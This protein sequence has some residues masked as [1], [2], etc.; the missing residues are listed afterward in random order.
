[1][2]GN[3]GQNLGKTRV[4]GLSR[5]FPGWCCWGL[6]GQPMAGSL[7][8]EIGSRRFFLAAPSVETSHEPR[9]VRQ[10]RHE[11]AA[12]RTVRPHEPDAGYRAA[13]F[14]PVRRPG[15]KYSTVDLVQNGKGS[16]HNSEGSGNQR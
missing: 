13:V 5:V 1:M 4:L 16:S 15:K 6:N 10:V 3:P 2:D 14:P 12:Q 8:L 7:L 11:M 9:Q